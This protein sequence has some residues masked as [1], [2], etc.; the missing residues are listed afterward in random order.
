MKRLI[1][2]RRTFSAT[3]GILTLGCISYAGGADVSASVATIV[4]GVAGANAYEGSRK[5]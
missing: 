5:H 3:L 1:T 2:C 4:L